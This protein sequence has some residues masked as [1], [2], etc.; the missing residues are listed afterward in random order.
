M[1]SH[2]DRYVVLD[3]CYN[4][5]DLGGYRAD[6]G[7]R[8]RPGLTFRSDALHHLSE[9]DVAHLRD[10]LRVGAIID[11]RSASELRME[12]RSPLARPPVRY[13][14]VPLFPETTERERQEL[15]AT[16]GDRYL[17]ILDFAAAPLA[18]VV[19]LIASSAEPLVFHCAAGKD[20]TGIISALLLSLLGVDEEQV[21]EDYVATSRN[22]GRIIA[23][24]RESP[25]YETIF[26]ELPPETLHAEAETMRSMLEAARQ[27]H[28]SMRG[29]AH[30]IGISDATIAQLEERLL[31]RT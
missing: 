24:L 21:I 7:R 9:A 14:H 5:R 23:R 6:D 3:G 11:V 10:A 25:S 15:P 19:Q 22:L 20:R 1:R 16:L 28:G 26:T 17:Q 8:V 29:Y 13:H 2:E 31:E 30:G 4:F 27:R 12:P 18:Q